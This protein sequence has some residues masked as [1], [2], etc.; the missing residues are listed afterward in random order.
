MEV[1]PCDSDSDSDT[2]CSM[3]VRVSVP[4]LWPYGA[5]VGDTQLNSTSALTG[6]LVSPLIHVPLG[7]SVADRFLHGLYVSTAHRLCTLS[8][9]NP[10]KIA[11][12]VIF[13]IFKDSFFYLTMPLEHINFHI[14]GYWMSNIWSF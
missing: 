4:R 14:I 1:K 3:L 13:F 8:L 2:D 6:E 5:G 11:A 10:L 12:F 7:L 9:P